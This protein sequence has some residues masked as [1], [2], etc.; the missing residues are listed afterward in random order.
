M[1]SSLELSVVS[2]H[3]LVAANSDRDGEVGGHNIGLHS[4]GDGLVGDLMGGW[5]HGRDMGVWETSIGEA[6]IGVASI[7]IGESHRG[8]NISIPL[9]I[10]I[11]MSISISMA[12]QPIAISMSISKAI[13]MS[14][15]SIEKVGVSFSLSTPLSIE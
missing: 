4:G 6:G 7:G 13:S 5:D 9:A 15:S 1:N 8:N 10:V 3:R 2:S 11:A 12:I 14:I